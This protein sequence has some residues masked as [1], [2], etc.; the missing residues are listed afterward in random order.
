MPT[1]LI[2]YDLTSPGRDYEPVWAYLKTSS[3]WHPLGSVW[4]IVTDKSA[5]TVRDDLKKLIDGND[6]VL[7]VQ[8]DGD[9][10]ATTGLD[11]GTDWMKRNVA[12]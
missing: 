4:I 7:V 1:H 9:S 3:H 8:V 11:E 10:W 12:S 5:R 6:R 2:S